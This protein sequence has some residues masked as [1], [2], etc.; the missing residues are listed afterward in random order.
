MSVTQAVGSSNLKGFA[1]LLGD[2][3]LF[4]RAFEQS[5]Q[6]IHQHL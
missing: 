4:E 6:D 3:D 5:T 2:G 1:N